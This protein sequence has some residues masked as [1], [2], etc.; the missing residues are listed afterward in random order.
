MHLDHIRERLGNGFKPFQ[1]QLSNGRKFEVPHP[2]FMSVGRNVVICLDKNS[3]TTKIDAAH[4]VL[5]EDLHPPR[6]K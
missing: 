5:V 6:R 4:I 3:L 1:M 2:D